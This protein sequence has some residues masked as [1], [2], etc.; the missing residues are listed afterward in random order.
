MFLSRKS[1]K[2]VTVSLVILGVLLTGKAFATTEQMNTT[3]VRMINQ[4]DAMFPLIDQA[5]LEQDPTAR[6]QFHFD[7]WKDVN[8]DQHD[9]LRQSLLKMREALK[10]QIN[11]SNLTP[12]EVSPINNDFV[13]R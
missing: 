2:I 13:G 11:Q 10:N 1:K 9:G 8:G 12:K 7:Q 6:L 4:I 5:S 3:L